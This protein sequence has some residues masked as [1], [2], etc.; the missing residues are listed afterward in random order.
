[1]AVYLSDL[2]YRPLVDTC[3][4]GAF[5]CGEPDLDKWFLKEGH[6]RH[7]DH[8]CR[9]T[10]VH[11]GDDLNPIAFYAL[12]LQLEDERYLTGDG[13]IRKR[14]ISKV[15]PALH[16][17]YVAVDKAYQGQDVGTD[18]MVRVIEVFRRSVLEFGLPVLTLVP[19]NEKLVAFYASVG[20]VR[21]AE[22]LGQRRMMMPARTALELPERAGV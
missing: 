2:Q 12:G 14:V 1:V 13:P 6:R 19:L 17:E 8:N 16:L 21:Y 4:R 3:P 10:T 11:I 15:F 9:V 22:R 7:S 20:F 18:I 5:R